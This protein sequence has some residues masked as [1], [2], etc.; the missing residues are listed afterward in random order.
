MIPNTHH[1]FALLACCLLLAGCTGSDSPVEDPRTNAKPVGA[2][3][4]IA[5]TADMPTGSTHHF[6]F[7]GNTP[8]VLINANGMFRAYINTCDHEGGP[9]VLDEGTLVCQWHEAQFDPVTGALQQG[10]ATGP[11]SAIPVTLKDGGVYLTE[12]L[13]TEGT[14]VA[15][16]IPTTPTEAPPAATPEPSPARAPGFV[17]RTGDVPPGST[18]E[19]NLEGKGAIL[20]NFNGEYRAYI[21]RC[22]HEGGPNEL[23]DT[24]IVCK[25][26]DSQFDPKTGALMRGPATAPL[27]SIAIEVRDGSVFVTSA[28]TDAP[29]DVPAPTEPPVIPTDA[30]VIPSEA[31]EPTPAPAP[32]FVALIDDVPPGSTYDFRF[33]GKPAI[34]INFNGLYR[35]YVNK[36]SHL[37]GPNELR[38]TAIV[39]KWHGAQFDPETGA[40]EKGPATAPL[41]QI[42]IT[43]TGD[44]IYAP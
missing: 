15:T 17:A 12:A 39:C 27:E 21:N 16:Q 6:L 3:G 41:E 42:P 35:A 23:R 1:L 13:K 5:R 33:E 38:D 43:I 31:P 40:L 26:H 44:S 37:G 25:W 2:D 30:P 32:G 36:C 11:L 20:I 14:V 29:T 34:I 4:L 22:N 24:A 8:A 10:P 18:Y 28:A 19:F 7:R 9:V